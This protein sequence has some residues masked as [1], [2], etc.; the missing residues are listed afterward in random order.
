MESGRNIIKKRGRFALSPVQTV[1][2]GFVLVIFAGAFLLSVPLSTTDN[3]WTP[4]IDALFISTSAV[5]VTGYSTLPV[6]FY[7]TGFGQA[8]LLLLVQIGGL[9]FMTVT[10]LVLMLMRKKI[11]FRDRLAIG[12]ALN[13]SGNKGI[14]RL[15]RKIV[16]MTLIT[17]FAGMLALIAPFCGRNGA[18][19]VWQ[20]AFTSVSAFCNAGFDIFARSANDFSGLNAYIDDVTVSL[21]IA[22]LIIAGGLGF[23]VISDVFKNKFRFKRFSFH[24]KLVL[25]V[26]GILLVAGWA[27]IFGVEYS[28][29]ATLG[30]HSAGVKLLSSFFQSVSCRTAGFSTVNQSDLRSASK[31]LCDILM[32]IGASPGSTG[33]G[34]KTTT[35]AVLVMTLVSGL[36]GR[37]GVAIGKH[38]VNQKT[39]YKS[40]SVTAASL[41]LVSALATLLLLTEK[42]YVPASLLSFEN[43]LHDSFSAFSTVGLTTNIIPYLSP[44]GK[45]FVAVVMF[46]GRVGLIPVAAA[47]SGTGGDLIRYPEAV[48]PVG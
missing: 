20:A 29:P 38:S 15:T 7:F 16:L 37:G 1:I 9:G 11:L 8:V 44:I 36:K 45:L 23:A 12:A 10:T 47:F 31:F 39:V 24:T 21:T 32:F 43:V 18:V 25:T 4:F 13:E 34:I 35:F 2:A 33:G 14:L 19:G 46:C 17:E 5:C 26:T 30:G 48:I 42:N 40:I 6:G 28:N 27:F 22:F 41:I 3:S